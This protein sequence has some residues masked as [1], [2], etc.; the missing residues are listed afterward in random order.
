MESNNRQYLTGTRCN[1]QVGLHFQGNSLPSY[2][3]D[4][5]RYEPLKRR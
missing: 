3:D 2:P 4:L 1:H 5:R